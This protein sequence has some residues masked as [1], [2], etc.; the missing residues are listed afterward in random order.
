MQDD[1]SI[2][3]FSKFKK[4]V[5][6]HNTVYFYIK[7]VRE[8]FIFVKVSEY[9]GCVLEWQN[10]INNNNSKIINLAQNFKIAQFN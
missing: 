1:R 8:K 7:N 3:F 9:F 10:N 2:M 6:Q 5:T 4:N